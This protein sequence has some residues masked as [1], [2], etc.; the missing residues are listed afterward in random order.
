LCG[1]TAGGFFEK[2]REKRKKGVVGHGVLFLFSAKN[3]G[4]DR[5]AVLFLKK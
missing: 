5:E 2:I 1:E 4:V 3:A